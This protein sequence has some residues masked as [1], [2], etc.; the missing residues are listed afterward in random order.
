[1][2]TPYEIENVR[3]RQTLL[4]IKAKLASP[5]PGRP[6]IGDVLDCLAMIDRALAMHGATGGPG[7]AL[8]RASGAPIAGGILAGLFNPQRGRP[9]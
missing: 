7:A 8:A 9:G 2:S 4:A 6:T 5:E 1:M 3:L